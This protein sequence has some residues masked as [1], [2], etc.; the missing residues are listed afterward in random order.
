[1]AIRR[2][3]K[4]VFALL[5]DIQDFEPIPR[6]EALRLTKDPSG[7][8]RVGTRRHEWVRLAFGCWLNVESVVSEL[9]P[10]H[11]YGMNF[12]S[13]WLT[14]HLT[15]EI[16]PTA[17]GCILRH[18]E[19]IRPRVQLRWPRP[20]IDRGMRPRLLRRLTDIKQILESAP[21]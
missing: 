3:P 7:P 16:E 2:P 1:M 20:V 17:D 13:R 9:E 4:A 10:P 6:N 14:G 21:A 8:T 11:R 15:Y 19:I 5:A 18:R 12:H